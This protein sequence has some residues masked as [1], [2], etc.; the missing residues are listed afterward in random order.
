MPHN[1]LGL[2]LLDSLKRDADDDDNG[3]AANTEV[4]ESS[5]SLK[6][7][8]HNSDDAKE[9]CA[10]ERNAGQDTGK[11]VSSRLARPESG[12]EPAVPL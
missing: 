7:D 11:D 1:H 3:G 9:Y 6:H 12:N 10:K 5:D 2:D 4:C 8:R